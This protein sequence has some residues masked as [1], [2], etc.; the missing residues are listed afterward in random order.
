MNVTARLNGRSWPVRV[1]SLSGGSNYKII[2][3]GTEL[4][5]AIRPSGGMGGGDRLVAVI[6]YN[7]C[8]CLDA[9]EW[10]AED[11]QHYIGVENQVDAATLAA[12]LNVLL[13]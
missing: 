13:R 4:L 1:V 5:V 10:T 9:R 11:I 7:R 3:R 2:G 6:N 12:A 8:G